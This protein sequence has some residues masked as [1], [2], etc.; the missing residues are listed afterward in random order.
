MPQEIGGHGVSLIFFCFER[1]TMQNEDTNK[2]KGEEYDIKS[3]SN[4]TDEIGFHC[5]LGASE[6]FNFTSTS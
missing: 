6:I 4:F 2:V 1:V 5:M 3:S